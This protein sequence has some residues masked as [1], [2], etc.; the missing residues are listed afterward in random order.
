[1]GSEVKLLFELRSGILKP[2][3]KCSGK[4]SVEIMPQLSLEGS[5]ES[6]VKG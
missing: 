3:L 4:F 1:M 5:I 2:L 6:S